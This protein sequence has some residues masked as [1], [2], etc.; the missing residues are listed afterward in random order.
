VLIVEVIVIFDDV[1]FL[2]CLKPE[3]GAVDM[4]AT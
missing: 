1:N 4:L 3:N 2:R